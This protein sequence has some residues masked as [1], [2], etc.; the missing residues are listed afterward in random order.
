M[1]RRRLSQPLWVLLVA[2]AV[3]AGSG[4]PECGRPPPGARLGAS[5]ANS[6]HGYFG[7][8]PR[9]DRTAKLIADSVILALTGG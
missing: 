6:A 2:T 3:L 9:T 7:R 5:A 4:L 1:L 8:L